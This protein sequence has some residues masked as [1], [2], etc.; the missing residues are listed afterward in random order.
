MTRTES[1]TPY[2]D[3]I[4]PDVYYKATK[5]AM[6]DVSRFVHTAGMALAWRNLRAAEPGDLAE[7][8][9]RAADANLFA[10]VIADMSMNHRK[11]LPD[12]YASW[13]YVKQGEKVPFGIFVDPQRMSQ[14]AE[15][16]RYPTVHPDVQ[17]ARCILHELGHVRV[18][19]WLLDG[20]GPD[21]E[22]GRDFPVEDG[23]PKARPEDEVGPWMYAMAVLGVI[24]AQHS[25]HS[26]REHNRDDTP[27]VQV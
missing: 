12:G 13:L 26:R 4:P 23:S 8:N 24:L 25:L 17:E 6:E 18:T 9:A 2:D 20:S 11:T 16:S 27:S 3:H 21:E 15:D 19:K 5:A 14:W 1:H 22:T 10:Q 7:C